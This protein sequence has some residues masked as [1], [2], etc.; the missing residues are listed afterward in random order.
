MNNKALMLYLDNPLRDQVAC[1][2][3]YRLNIAKRIHDRILFAW[4]NDKAIRSKLEK[5]HH[6]RLN[7][8]AF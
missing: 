7:K 4:F 2:P 6:Y 5:R 8:F 1:Y 3:W